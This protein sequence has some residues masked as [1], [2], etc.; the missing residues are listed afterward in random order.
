MADR[1]FKSTGIVLHPEVRFIDMET[2]EKWGT[3]RKPIKVLVLKGGVS[4]EREISLLSAENVAQTLRDGGFEV[5]EYDI[6]EL[7]I[8]DD[9]RWADVVY[10]V[11]HG[12]FGEDGRLQKML[13]D[14]GICTVGSPSKAMQ[15]VMDKTASK[16]VMDAN[17]VRNPRYAVL[18]D[19][20]AP[21]PEGMEL[22]L[23]VKPNSEGSTFGL[24]LVET[25]DQWKAAVRMA[26]DYDKTVLVEEYIKGI[27][28]T[29]GILLGK[30][31]PLIEIRYPGKLY[32]YDA[33][34][35]HAHGETQYICPPTGISEKAQQEARDLSL[36]FAKEVGASDLLRVDVII[37]ESDDKVFVLEG[38]SMPG[39]T[40]SSLLPK[41]AL[42]SGVSLLELYAGLVHSALKKSKKI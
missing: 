30:A 7:V 28:A 18:T 9:M 36:R 14:A 21:I 23:I 39:C 11:L 8:T 31:L 37:R 33:K 6:Q 19:P 4:S 35:T 25:A 32:D 38:N 41:A 29:V 17:E 10:P 5:R 20:N 24:T 27:E 40:A 2:A 16:K 22:P 34:Y 15:I 42:A 3:T 26:L 13:E 12:G 1:V